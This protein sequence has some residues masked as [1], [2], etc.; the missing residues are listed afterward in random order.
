M[1]SYTVIYQVETEI[2]AR[3]E[4]QAVQRA[5]QIADMLQVVAGPGHHSKRAWWP[6][7]VEVTDT[8]V[9]EA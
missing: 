7:V 9:S 6:E 3:N 2:Q 5:E 1:K 8:Q 4:A